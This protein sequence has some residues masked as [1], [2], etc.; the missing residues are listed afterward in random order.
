MQST[1]ENYRWDAS[2]MSNVVLV[3]VEVRRCPACGEQAV[4]IPRIEELHRSLAMT[5]IAHPGRLPPQEIR[6]LRKWLGW[7]GQDF[8]RHFGVTATTVSRWE[9]VEDPSPMGS[10]AERLLRLS[11]AHGQPA[12]EYPVSRLAELDEDA[13]PPKL[14]G[15][16]PS[17]TGWEPAPLAA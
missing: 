10:T 17:R 3:D 2:G 5:I 14:I 15:L 6:F 11:V 13:A 16:K 4:V 12:A 9:S 1:R 8:A 7:S